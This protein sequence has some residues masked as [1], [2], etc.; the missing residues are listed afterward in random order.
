MRCMLVRPCVPRAALEGER[1]RRRSASRFLG[2]V[3]GARL[4][5][6]ALRVSDVVT[7][8]GTVDGSALVEKAIVFDCVPVTDPLS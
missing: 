1:R 4:P 8:D 5:S 6:R 7:V 2:R 3:F